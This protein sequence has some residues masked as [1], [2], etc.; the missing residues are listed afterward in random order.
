M[1][2]QHYEPVDYFGGQNGFEETVKRDGRKKELCSKAGITLI[3]VTHKDDIGESALRI[4][5]KYKKTS[6]QEN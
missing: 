5:N 1:G 6:Q 4:W 3:Y 2:I